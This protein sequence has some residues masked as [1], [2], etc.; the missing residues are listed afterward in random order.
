MKQW[1]VLGVV[2]ATGFFGM[3]TLVTAKP[4]T[5][6]CMVDESG[7]FTSKCF[8]TRSECTREARKEKKTCG[9]TFE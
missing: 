8:S 3:N 5:M 6:Y 2:A 9:T 1:I 7:N 4:K